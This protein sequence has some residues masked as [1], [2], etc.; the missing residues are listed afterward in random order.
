MG[1][2]LSIIRGCHPLPFGHPLSKGGRIF[3]T[4]SHTRHFPSCQGDPS[5]S[6]GMTRR[7]MPSRCCRK[8]RSGGWCLFE[9]LYPLP[10]PGPF[11]K[12]PGKTV[13]PLECH[14]MLFPV[15]S[16]RAKSRNPPCTSA[17]L[18]DGST[19]LH[20]SYAISHSPFS[21]LPG[22]SLGFARDDEAGNAGMRQPI[23]S[24]SPLKF[25]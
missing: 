4:R 21:L 11:S 1:R 23:P 15:S 9:A 18:P 24:F 3:S 5:A 7:E 6:L 25:R 19:G 10:L 16:F 8:D 20:V 12:G 14:T 22:R 13:L 2:A 17:L